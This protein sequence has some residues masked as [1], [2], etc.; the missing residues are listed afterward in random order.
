MRLS[1]QNKGGTRIP[2]ARDKMKNEVTHDF[3]KLN[4]EQTQESNAELRDIGKRNKGR[5]E[6]VDNYALQIKNSADQHLQDALRQD[7]LCMFQETNLS[8]QAEHQ[9]II[10]AIASDMA[11]ENESLRNSNM[12]AENEN[13]EGGKT[14]KKG[15][16]P[17][18]LD[19][20]TT[21]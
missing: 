4:G 15:S 3:F 10:A 8:R 12:A 16:I 7:K 17:P 11:T 2:T 13:E 6:M 14:S 18:Q 9:E 19:P 21:I 20:T 5:A 1:H